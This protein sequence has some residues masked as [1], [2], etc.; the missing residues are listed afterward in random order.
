MKSAFSGGQGD[1]AEHR[2]LGGRT[3]M[4]LL[5][6]ISYFL[7]DDDELQSIHDVCKC[8]TS[9]MYTCRNIEGYG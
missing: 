1:I 2:K 7:D 8:L 6:H 5:I 3:E 4:M 9:L